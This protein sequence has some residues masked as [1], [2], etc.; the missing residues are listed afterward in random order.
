MKRKKP[1]KKKKPPTE[2]M[3]KTMALVKD[4]FSIKRAMIEAGYS[5]MTAQ[6]KGAEYLRR[7]DLTEIKRGL[8]IQNAISSIKAQKVLSEK[9][10]SAEK[11]GD[12]IK[13][14]DAVLRASKTF[15]AES[16]GDTTYTFVCQTITGETIN[17]GIPQKPDGIEVIDVEP[18]TEE[19]G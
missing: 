16:S 19:G 9:M 6:K 1:K 15:L 17:L 8:R 13:A 3:A 14:A 11:E 18:E 7:L 10:T 2:R 12:Q 5:P 4:G